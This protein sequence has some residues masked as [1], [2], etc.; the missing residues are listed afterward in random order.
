M[1]R[2][3]SVAKRRPRPAKP[4]QQPR[5][6]DRA[7]LDLSRKVYLSVDHAMEYLDL[8]SKWSVYRW[9]RTSAIRKYRVGALI[10]F[11]RAEIDRAVEQGPQA[12]HTN[13]R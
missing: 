6:L 7:P 5:A 10:R 8:P 1:S 4:Q 2:V 12:P 3:N 13:G 11:R 9:A